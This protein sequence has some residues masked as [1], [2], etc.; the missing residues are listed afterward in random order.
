MVNNGVILKEDEKEHLTYNF[1]E[2]SETIYVVAVTDTLEPFP[3]QVPNF[4]QQEN[5]REESDTS[6][7]T[8]CNTMSSILNDATPFNIFFDVDK[9]IIS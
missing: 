7:C 5:A 9:A 4:L 8:E 2:Q 6:N 1:P 3:M